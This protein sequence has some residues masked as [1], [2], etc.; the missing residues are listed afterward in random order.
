MTHILIILGFMVFAFLWGGIPVGYVVVKQIKG[1]DIRKYGS[2]NIGATNVR[3]VLGT[4]WLREP[5]RPS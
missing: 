2:G 5:S 1:L 3:R 4:G